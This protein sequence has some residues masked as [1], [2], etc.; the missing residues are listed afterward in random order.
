M[1]IFPMYLAVPKVI[2]HLLKVPAIVIV[3]CNLNRQLR[4][5]KFTF[6]MSILHACC[7]IA[8]L[9]LLLIIELLHQY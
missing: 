3:L 6:I 1:G 5:N 7:K 9:I 4:K 8:W 2:I